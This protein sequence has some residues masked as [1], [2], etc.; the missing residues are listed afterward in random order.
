MR[1]CLH[2]LEAYL[3]ADDAHPPLVRLA[4]IH[5]QFEAIHP[6]LDGNG[7]IGRLLIILLM[8]HWGLAALA[9]A[10]SQRVFR[11]SSAGLLRPAPNCEYARTLAR[12]AAVFP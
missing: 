4:L 6:F 2:E 1:Q 9:D 7:R 11:A 8:V 12:L 10:V 5:Y 3:H